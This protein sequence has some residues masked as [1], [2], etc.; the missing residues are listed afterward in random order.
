MTDLPAGPSVAVM[1]SH[2]RPVVAWW[3]PPAD[4]PTNMALDEALAAESLRLDRVLVRI[5]TW[6]EPT[7]SLGAFQAIGEAR[8][9]PALAG[10]PIVRRPSG[11]GAIVHGS[12]VTLSLAVPRNHPCGGVPQR[13]YDAVHGALVAELAAR[14]VAAATSAGDAAV[15]EEPAQEGLPGQAIASR[16][17]LLCFD[18]RAVGDVVL[19][20]A[21]GRARADAKILGSAQRRL[22]G[23]VLQHGSLLLAANRGVPE[24]VRHP[25]LAELARP[26]GAV[27]GV[28]SWGHDVVR[29]WVRRLAE[30]LGCG[31]DEPGGVFA[32]SPSAGVEAG[33]A[34]F[35]EDSWNARR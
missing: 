16:P 6:S 21:D 29:G 4:G 20:V 7:V 3:D 18:R 30:V 1:P 19:P 34:R 15:P 10:L 32:P 8:A 5:S 2:G 12:D 31:L 13:L 35:R 24:A 17:P 23:A 25:G 28:G 27:D 22:G 14:G 26:S 11:G 9:T 33:R